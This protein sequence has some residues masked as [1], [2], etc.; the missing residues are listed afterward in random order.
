MQAKLGVAV[1]AVATAREAVSGADIVMCATN[2][3]E[4]VVAK[5][6]LEP[7]MHVSSL[8]RLELDSDVVAAADVVVIHSREVGGK[9]VRTAG[10]DLARETEER[11]AALAGKTDLASR[12]ELSDLLLGRVPGRRSDRDV[13]LFLN[14][15]GL[16]YQFAA[17]GHVVYRRA[18]ELKLGRELDT[19]LFTSG[20][21]S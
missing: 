6:W 15:A 21:P 4:P 12:P 11:K 7:G 17:T 18:R 13:T 16:G 14:Y 1:D 8:S 9:I 10:A 20:L 2:S 19:D 5:D 3:L